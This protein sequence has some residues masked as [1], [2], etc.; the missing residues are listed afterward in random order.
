RYLRAG[1]TV[2]YLRVRRGSHLP[3]EFLIVPAILD[4]LTDRFAGDP[5]PTG[6]CTVASVAR[7]PRALRTH[8]AFARTVLRMLGGMP[9]GG[10]E[11]VASPERPRL[12]GGDSEHSHVV[13]DA[14]IAVR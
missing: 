8:L 4:W 1:A 13:D 11:A 14:S 9:I 12:G 2:R 3:L 10:K 7:S 5:A 6:T